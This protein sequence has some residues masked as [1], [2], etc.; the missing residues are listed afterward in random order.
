[1]LPTPQG[2]QGTAIV[3]SSARPTRE[4]N[5]LQTEHER[6]RAEDWGRD[7]HHAEEASVG[8]LRR[9]CSSANNGPF[10]GTTAS[11]SRASGGS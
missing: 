7:C 1:M 9:D 3:F 4:R 2:T 8:L 6:R 10:P 5:L 11:G